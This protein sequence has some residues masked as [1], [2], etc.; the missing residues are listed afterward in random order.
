LTRAAILVLAL[1]IDPT[2]EPPPQ[3]KPLSLWLALGPQV[4]VG[5]TPYPAG[6]L[7]GKVTLDLN[8]VSIEVSIGTLMQQ[9]L[10]RDGG[11]AIRISVP[12]EGGLAP[13]LGLQSERLLVQGCL[14]IQ[15]GLVL[16][17]AEGVERPRLGTAALLAA[18][19]RIQARI[20]L[21]SWV[22]LRLVGDALVAVFR[23]VF[24]FADGSEA[25]TPSLFFGAGTLMVEFKVW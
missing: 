3:V 14:A 20:R 19:P 9:R 18:G 17:E 25:W 6:G 2:L 4:V 24:L 21:T 22:A 12:I 11:R 10:A 16:G 15:A 5:A 23:P 1:A 8:P 7:A 13:C